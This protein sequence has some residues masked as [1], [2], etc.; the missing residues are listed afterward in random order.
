MPS[1]AEPVVGTSTSMRDDS[2]PTYFPEGCPPEDAYAT[3]EGFVRMVSNDPPTPDDFLTTHEE[4]ERGL[5][6][7]LRRSAD[8][9]MVCGA[10]LFD[11][12]VR[13]RRVRDA[14]PPLR[15]KLLAIGE[16]QGEGLVKRTGQ[17]PGHF[18]WWRRVGERSAWRTFNVVDEP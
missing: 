2:W 4:I 14:L 7:P 9:C 18:T 17:K 8:P 6:P 15:S 12:V 1:V 11:S 3:A 13:A 5:K 16:L 10:S